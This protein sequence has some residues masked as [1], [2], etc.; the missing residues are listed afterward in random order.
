VV[1]YDTGLDRGLLSKSLEGS[2]RRL[3]DQERE[4]TAALASALEER[5]ATA[6]EPPRP[7]E[8]RGLAGI[9]SEREMLRFAVEL[10]NTIV[11]AYID[12]HRKLKDEALLRTFAQIMASEGQHLVVLRQALGDDPLPSAFEA[13]TTTG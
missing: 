9:K 5:G 2:A 8:V 1:A 11:I 4:H 12:A 6:P 3:R 7:G 13:G 10:E